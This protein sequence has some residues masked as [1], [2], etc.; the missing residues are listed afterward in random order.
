VF[1]FHL[2]KLDL[3]TFTWGHRTTLPAGCGWPDGKHQQCHWSNDQSAV[4]IWSNP[5]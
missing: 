3:Q 5:I 4:A 1:L 2:S